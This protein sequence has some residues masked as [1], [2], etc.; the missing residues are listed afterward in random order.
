MV[1]IILRNAQVEIT[2]VG[3]LHAKIGLYFS[4]VIGDKVCIHVEEHRNSIHH[5]P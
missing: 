4:Q 2:I 1:A 3:T 5:I